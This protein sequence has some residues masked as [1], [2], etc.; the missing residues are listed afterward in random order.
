MPVLRSINP[1]FVS[2]LTANLDH[3]R[4]DRDLLHTMAEKVT[5]TAQVEDGQVSLTAPGPLLAAASRGR[6][7]GEAAFG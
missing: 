3:L 2:T 7:G 6:S 5:R 1:S 4:E